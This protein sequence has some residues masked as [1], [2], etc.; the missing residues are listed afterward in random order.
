MAYGYD[1]KGPIENLGFEVENEK[2][3]IQTFIGDFLVE[4]IQN[5]LEGKDYAETT[6]ETFDLASTQFNPGGY[7]YVCSMSR[8]NAAFS[9]LFDIQ[10]FKLETENDKKCDAYKYCGSHSADK[11]SSD[12][13][14]YG[15][16]AALVN[17]GLGVKVSDEAFWNGGLKPGAQIQY[18]DKSA[19]DQI[20]TKDD[21]V[22]E[23]KDGGRL[24]GHSVIFMEY[25]SD[26]EGDYI[27]Y[28]DYNSSRSHSEYDRFRKSD[29]KYKIFYGVNL[30]NPKK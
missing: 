28:T 29:M 18:W 22:R 6:F 19:D 30:V 5:L 10:P 2:K 9:E 8:V 16:G 23:L 17:M 13:I 21:V 25:G 4:F 26:V 12:L 24:D 20:Q 1:K 14:G 3:Q 7:C 27:Q 15:V 11:L